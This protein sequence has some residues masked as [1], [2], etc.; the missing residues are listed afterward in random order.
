MISLLSR[1]VFPGFVY[2][3]EKG[4]RAV[5][6]KVDK[7]SLVDVTHDHV[8]VYYNGGCSFHGEEGA[9]DQAAAKVLAWFDDDGA[10]GKAAIVECSAGKVSQ[11]AASHPPQH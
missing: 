6:L 5:S 4:S 1:T 11:P 3:S 10:Q 2:E 9:G 8:K 7:A